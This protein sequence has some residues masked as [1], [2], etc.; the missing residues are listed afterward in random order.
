MGAGIGALG[1]NVMEDFAIVPAAGIFTVSRFVGVFCQI[2][3]TELVDLSILHPVETREIGFR[4][5]K[6][7]LHRLPTHRQPF[8]HVEHIRL[9]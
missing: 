8:I 1:R 7:R 4:Q 5:I 6:C 3:I 9:G 2:Q